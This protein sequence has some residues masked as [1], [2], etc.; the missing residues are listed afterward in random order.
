MIR[1]IAEA[2]FLFLLPFAGF[3]IWL[4]TKGFNPLEPASWSRSALS[5]LTIVALGL[6]IASV[7]FVG[8]TRQNVQGVFVPS[9]VKDGQF[10]PGHF[11]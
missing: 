1:A 11:R 3:A 10:I 6:C 9:H 5:S 8:A 4:L 7:V 2:I